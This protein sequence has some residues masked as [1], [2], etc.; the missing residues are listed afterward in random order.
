MSAYLIAS[1]IHGSFE[2]LM[3]LVAEHGDGRQLI[4]LGDLIDRGPRSREVVEY[5]MEHKTPTCGGNHE[6]LAVAYSKHQRL[7]YKAHC[8][9][10]YDR[11][12]W[13]NNGGDMALQSW[14][15]EW[16]LGSTLPKDVLDWMAALPPY[17][18]IDTPNAAGQKLLCSHTGY[19]FSADKGD[20]LT[21]LWG[22][23]GYD[24]GNFP[25]DGYYRVIGHTKR[26]E[27]HVTKTYANIDTGCAYEG[28][29]KL[30]ALL[31]PEC[32]TVSVDNID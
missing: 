18:I 29:G 20:W 27:A 12:V 10:Y 17:L 14:H 11:D 15:G 3:K 30:S 1:D 25:N 7:G 22:R 24:R 31:W 16:W 19:G 26:R 4:L 6:D 5:A 32:T 2:T 8:T 9:R 13:L 28:Y 23:I 21:A